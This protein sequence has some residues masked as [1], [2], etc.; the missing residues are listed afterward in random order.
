MGSYT[1]TYKSVELFKLEGARIYTDRS[2]NI[3]LN[4]LST[5]GI[6][7]TIIWI[8]LQVYIFII[9]LE[10]IRSI[11]DINR[12]NSNLVAGSI[13]FA[14]IFQSLF[15]SDHIFLVFIGYISAGIVLNL[16][17]FEKGAEKIKNTKSY[18]NLVIQVPALILV[19]FSVFSGQLADFTA[20]KI[21][22]SNQVTPTQIQTFGKY[23]FNTQPLELFAYKLIDT[24]TNCS[25]AS[26][27]FDRM[28]KID[29][30]SSQAWNGKAAC[31]YLS[32]DYDNQIKF[33]RKALAYDPLNDDYR[34]VLIRGLISTGNTTEAKVEV[35]KYESLFG[36][37]PKI[38]NLKVQVE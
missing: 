16:N 2:H 25:Y 9:F 33:I 13:W 36:N 11:N 35:K 30:R 31:S 29:S 5:Q 38:K 37:D 3:I 1:N 19:V 17:G 6:F 23:Q 12:R 14:Y 18:L 8:L 27:L 28:L 7:F 4:L 32:K 20:R 24:P 22:I 10:N 15:S 34:I 26:P 21:M